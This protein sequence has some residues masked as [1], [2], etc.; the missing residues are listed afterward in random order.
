MNFEDRLSG[1]D[2]PIG[3]FLAELESQGFAIGVDHYIQI[4][5]LLSQMDLFG[6]NEKQLLKETLAPIIVTSAEEQVIFYETFDRFFDGIEVLKVKEGY[7]QN[8][9][10]VNKPPIVAK[11]ESDKASPN[12]TTFLLVAAG[13]ILVFAALLF[14]YSEYQLREQQSDKSKF[15][16]DI[17]PD[18]NQPSPEAQFID[19]EE[20]DEKPARNR[21][22]KTLGGLLAYK[23]FIDPD[24]Q[25]LEI[26]SPWWH[27]YGVF[28]NWWIILSM[29]AL[30]LIY[31]YYLYVRDRVILKKKSK[32]K[33]PEPL[34]LR[35]SRKLQIDLGPEF[36]KLA[37][38]LRTRV[39]GGSRLLDIPA[40]VAA[41]A[42]HSGWLDLRFKDDS[43][44]AEYL[45][46]IYQQH[47][48]D[49]RAKLV[50]HVAKKLQQQGIHVHTYFFDDYIEGYFADQKSKPVSLNHL[51]FHYGGH[52]LLVCGTT[53]IILQKNRGS[54]AALL[55]GLDKWN[56]RVLLNY[57]AAHFWGTEEEKLQEHLPILPD[58]PEGWSTLPDLFAGILQA[59]EVDWQQQHFDISKA[60]GAD[61]WLPEIPELAETP[62]LQQW[63]V[64]CC[65][66]P[67]LRWELTLYFGDALQTRSE[68]LLTWD[69]LNRLA[70]A[71]WFAQGAVD[72]THRQR[73]LTDQALTKKP[74]FKQATQA[75][76]NLLLQQLEGT[77]DATQRHRL[78]LH[79]NISSLLLA[80]EPKLRQ[81]I[82]RQAQL[83]YDSLEETEAATLSLLSQSRIKALDLLFSGPLKQLFFKNG[84]T[85]RGLQRWTRMGLAVLLFGLP[86]L[87]LDLEVN[88]C[89]KMHFTYMSEDYCPN[90]TNKR[91][92]FQTH[93]AAFYQHA[94]PMAWEN[95]NMHT[96]LTDALKENPQYAPALINL[97]LKNYNHGINQF[98][99]RKEPDRLQAAIDYWSE[100]RSLAEQIQVNLQANIEQRMQALEESEQRNEAGIEHHQLL[101][102]DLARFQQY[103]AEF[104][105][106]QADNEHAIGLASYFLN[107]RYAAEAI[108]VNLG[109]SYF[110]GASTPN[111]ETLLQ[112][113]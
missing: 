32:L 47:P 33:N 68:P 30:L 69:Q 40:T 21:P 96:H 99:L 65:L 78:Q 59:N 35:T 104:T 90:S 110:A 27:S 19:D 54:H 22:G 14:T 73:I 44:P 102:Q 11:A 17:P 66:Y 36:L 81:K 55:E 67:Q 7:A 2:F 111:L 25:L 16:T 57:K 89:R 43:R 51:F 23:K 49:H 58:T 42:R 93:R 37:H 13:L 39:S 24:L 34:V 10:A 41:T 20:T 94:K 64:A 107:D 72:E 6:R 83:L 26:P 105:R 98:S 38:G 88:S 70:R 71:S 91:A 50:S 3:P 61:N 82:K 9:N 60:K 45:L 80:E 56:E 92:A 46:L 63:A 108:Y 101:E 8:A 85:F 76:R 106:H 86:F 87:L 12:P 5:R 62:A 18:L 53:E 84:V 1:L 95:F 103:A 52:R 109:S 75:L 112:G 77:E 29:A 113:Q 4:R 15:A 48:E 79:I 97:F 74:A 31:E 28:V 100:N